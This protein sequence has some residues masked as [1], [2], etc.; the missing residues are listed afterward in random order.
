M[1]YTVLLRNSGIHWGTTAGLWLGPCHEGQRTKKHSCWIQLSPG[2]TLPRYFALLQS[3]Q[4]H[5]FRDKTKI[6]MAFSSSFITVE[7]HIY[8]E[9]KL[10]HLYAYISQ[11]NINSLKRSLY[12]VSKLPSLRYFHLALYAK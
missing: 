11:S 5:N 10:L 12:S 7:R 6:P 2:D 9:F 1:P 3:W 8:D 4:L